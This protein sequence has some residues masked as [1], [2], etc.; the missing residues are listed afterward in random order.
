MNSQTKG[1]EKH[2]RQTER[3]AELAPKDWTIRRGSM[4]IRGVNPFGP[5]FFEL[6]GE[7][8]PVYAMDAITPTH[9]PDAATD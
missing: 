3:S 8:A 4:P 7:G 6:A 1:D 2:D 5:D 9:D